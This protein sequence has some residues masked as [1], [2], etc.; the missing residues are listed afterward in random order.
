MD[1]QRAAVNAG[2][3]VGAFDDAEG[4]RQCI[5]VPVHPVAELGGVENVHYLIEELPAV[6]GIVFVVLR[7]ELLGQARWRRRIDARQ[8]AEVVVYEAVDASLDGC[9][10]R[11]CRNDALV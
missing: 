6:D 10:D 8:S 2:R 5:P 7:L 11:L 1:S 3:A 9:D 4:V